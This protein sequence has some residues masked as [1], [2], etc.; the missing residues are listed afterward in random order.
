MPSPT[1]ICRTE[2]LPKV[3]VYAWTLRD[4]LPAIPVPLASGD[5]DVQLDLQAAFTKTYDRSGYDYALNYRR[6]VEPPLDAALS[7]WMRTVLGKKG[8]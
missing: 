5:A 2:R 6:P 4:R 1:N 8:D 3:A 7:E